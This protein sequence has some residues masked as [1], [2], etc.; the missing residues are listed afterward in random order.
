[1]GDELELGQIVEEVH[2][3]ITDVSN[4]Q[5]DGVKNV[6]SGCVYSL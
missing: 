5:P 6:Y 4:E 1:M 3:E 2:L